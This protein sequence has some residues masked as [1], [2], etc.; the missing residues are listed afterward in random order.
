[1]KEIEVIYI[2]KTYLDLV[3]KLNILTMKPF[4]FYD[5]TIEVINVK[6][7]HHP[8]FSIIPNHTHPFFEFNYLIQGDLYTNIEGMEFSISEKQS[9]IVTPGSVHSHRK[10]TMDSYTDIC[11]HFSIKPNQSKSDSSYFNHYYN[12]LMHITPST[13]NSNLENLYI[14]DNS[15]SAQLTFLTWLTTLTYLPKFSFYTPPKRFHKISDAVIEYME[16]NYFE[17]INVNNIADALNISY[18]SL[19]RH[20]K[21]ETGVSL[22][23]QLNNIRISHA[24][25][26]LTTTDFSLAEIAKMTGFDNEHYFSFVFRTHTFTTPQK[27]RQKNV[28]VDGH[29]HKNKK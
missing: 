7:I 19:A 26:L 27:F 28:F 25:K 12:N 16:M 9:Y 6:L 18:R 15:F 21:E 22:I 20:F 17:S 13:F 10:Y 5:L 3:K 29:L 1:M 24:K 8:N 11:I 14:E 2:M 23:F 4:T